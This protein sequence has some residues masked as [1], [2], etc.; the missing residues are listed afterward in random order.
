MIRPGKAVLAAALWVGLVVSG[1]ASAEEKASSV[2]EEFGM[3][4]FHELV[5][6]VHDRERV[7]AAWRE[8]AGWKEVARGALAPEV[9]ALWG[10]PAGTRGEET[11]LGNPGT[12]RGFLRLVELT[13]PADLRDGP[14]RL[15]R[16]GQ[17]SWDTGG[18]FD[19]NV[20]AI[21][22]TASLERLQ[23]FGWD[24]MSEPVE[25][26]FG[27]FTVREVLARGPDGI[28]VAMIERVAPTLEGWPHL[29]RLS[30][31]FN[32]T[33]IVRDF[34]T[35]LAFYREALG[36]EI[37]LEHH[38][39]SKQPGPNVLGLPHNLATEIPRRVAILSPAGDNDGSVE[40]LAFEGAVGSDYSARSQAPNLGI[41]SMRFPVRRLDAYLARL[42][43]H[44]IQPVAAPRTVTIEPLGQ[45]RLTAVRSPEG[46]WIE[47]YEP[48][49]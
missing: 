42:A 23:R 24:A 13:A 32:A 27:P 40:I 38:G 2:A 14:R 44:G 28:V 33:Q 17:Q 36:F 6:V 19:F 21:D 30:R 35:A 15:M 39:A 26:T 3:G 18:I 22:V 47:L 29:E 43:E 45:V 34:D 12:D 37:Y 16:P 1:P 5:I 10:L 7:A 4:G 8:V 9:V 41:H 11:V 48:L 20:R 49:P 31:V 46:A 25:F